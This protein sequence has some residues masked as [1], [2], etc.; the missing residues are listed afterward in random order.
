MSAIPVTLTSTP[1]P[2]L[3]ESPLALATLAAKQ[4]QPA[5]AAARPRPRA[6]ARPPARPEPGAAPKASAPRAPAARTPAAKGGAPRGPALQRRTPVAAP[7]PWTPPRSVAAPAPAPG[8][9]KASSA[10]DWAFLSDPKLS[11]EEKLA[12][13]AAV[14][15]REIDKELEAKMA[16]YKADFVDKKATG[17]GSGSTKGAS[18]FDFVKSVVPGMDAVVGLVGEGAFKQAASKLGG[19]ALAAAAT[20]MGFPELAPLALKYGGDLAALA[21][22]DVGGS[23][24]AKSGSSSSAAQSAG[25]PDEKMAMMEIQLLVEKEQRMFSAISNT[26]KALHDTQMAAVHNLR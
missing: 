19:P 17:S 9:A 2:D 14:A 10:G 24:A 5:R 18:V 25:S 7:G 22:T 16:K 11:I 6:T 13:F 20:A 12:R 21:F 26:L 4:R 1:L 15:M 23:S 3:A 8:Y